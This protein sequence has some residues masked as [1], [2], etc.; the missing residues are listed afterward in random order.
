MSIVDRRDD[1]I[2]IIDVLHLLW[3][4][5]WILI[6]GMVVGLVA[7]YPVSMVLPDTIY[8]TVTLTIYP[9]GTPTDTADD[10]KNQLVA[11]LARKG[12]TATTV[13]NSDN[14]TIAM[15]YRAADLGNADGKFVM[16]AKAVSDYRV[17]LLMKVSGAYF[18]LQQ[19][20]GVEGR[21]DTLVKF[22]SFQEGVADGSIDPVR[23]SVVET[24]R[25]KSMKATAFVSLPILGL[26]A[27]VLAVAATTTFRKLRAAW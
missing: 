13:K 12:F 16:L 14:L 21:A 18:D 23:I 5:K 4:S 3:R 26:V 25:R 22:R 24:D 2:S 17:R 7:I 15:P 27:G 19:R 8:R 6:A 20:E 11:I 9:S 1:E 10:V